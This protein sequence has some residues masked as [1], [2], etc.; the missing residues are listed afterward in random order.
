MIRQIRPCICSAPFDEICEKSY[1]SNL[2]GL[3]ALS[4]YLD[5]SSSA[6][7]RIGTCNNSLFCSIRKSSMYAVVDCRCRRSLYAASQ[8]TW[9]VDTTAVVCRRRRRQK[10]REISFVRLHPEAAVTSSERA[11]IAELHAHSSSGEDLVS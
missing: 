6:T 11:I 2:L 3:K 9:T 10:W 5:E 8:I 4:I 7:K 1:R